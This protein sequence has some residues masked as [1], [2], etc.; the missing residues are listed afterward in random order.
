MFLSRYEDTRKGGSKAE[1]LAAFFEEYAVPLSRWTG[2][3]VVLMIDP[4]GKRLLGCATP[5]QLKA[6]VT[7]HPFDE[8]CLNGLD[9][10]A[11][12]VQHRDELLDILLVFV[13]AGVRDNA[14]PLAE[15]PDPILRVQFMRALLVVM[16]DHKSPFPK[17]TWVRA[18]SS[19][20]SAWADDFSDFVEGDGMLDLD[21]S[22]KFPAISAYVSGHYAEF[23]AAAKAAPKPPL[24][25]I[26]PGKYSE[27]DEDDELWSTFCCDLEPFCRVKD[28]EYV[29]D[30]LCNVLRHRKPDIDWD[31]LHLQEL[32]SFVE[33]DTWW[34]DEDE[35]EDCE[36]YAYM[37]EHRTE[38]VTEAVDIET[39]WD[40]VL[41]TLPSQT[42]KESD[43]SALVEAGHLPAM[44]HAVMQRLKGTMF[45]P[46]L[47]TE[48]W[49][50]FFLGR[51]TAELDN[52]APSTRFLTS[53]CDEVLAEA[54]ECTSK[55]LGEVNEA[56]DAVSE[57]GC[58]DK[59]LIP[60]L[61]AV[62]AGF[63]L[64]LDCV[65]N[66]SD[67]LRWP[68]PSVPGN[69][70]FDRRAELIRHTLA[71]AKGRQQKKP[72][73]SRDVIDLTIE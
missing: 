15:E 22:E 12:F 62:A 46:A 47:S 49:K 71:R 65:A 33:G 43:A 8:R 45:E 29:A 23:V 32:M 51:Y 57:S 48:G 60:C 70:V 55:T 1:A 63:G 11:E 69:P 10:A 59:Q 31:A 14:Y 2:P 73:T 37:N 54:I 16:R 20:R 5:E 39:Q 67:F 17:I 35:Q 21:W 58:T 66:L 24:T 13:R 68:I 53:N 44:I 64:E 72:R 3:A 50:Q 34:E 27:D 38:L 19:L 52:F 9:F 36:A 56:L 6:F 7:A 25:R 30:T 61:K 41:K 4:L 40:A 26:E 28:S 18:I 42:Y